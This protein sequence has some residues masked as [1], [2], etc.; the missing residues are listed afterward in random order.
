[1]RKPW[2]C[3]CRVPANMSSQSIEQELNEL[4][5]LLASVSAK[6]VSVEAQAQSAA[7]PSDPGE[8]TRALIM[9]TL[10]TADH[11]KPGFLSHAQIEA[12][13]NITKSA[14]HTHVNELEKKGRVWIR[15]THNPKNGRP[16]F[17]VYHPA[18]VRV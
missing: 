11:G 3:L 5:S 15:K 12:A 16:C 2:H 17:F 9:R 4:R 13:C 1:M 18:A 7:S 8:A 10:E 6:I 14:S